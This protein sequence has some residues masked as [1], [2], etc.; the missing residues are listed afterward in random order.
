M[1]RKPA[2]QII[3]THHIQYP[4][5]GKPQDEITVKVTQ[6][7]HYVLTVIQRLKR[8]LSQGFLKALANNVA[9][10]APGRE[11][12]STPLSTP[13]QKLTETSEI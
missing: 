1:K 7:E 10:H 2:H 9:Q 12:N 3:Q 5:P 4:V 6:S 8:P 11:L 13:V